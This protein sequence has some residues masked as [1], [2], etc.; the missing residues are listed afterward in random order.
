MTR[1]GGIGLV[2]A[3]ALGLLVLGGGEEDSPQ[4]KALDRL[5]GKLPRLP[6]WPVDPALVSRIGDALG[7]NRGHQGVDLFVPAKTDVVAPEA[8]RI[9]RSVNGSKGTTDSQKRAGQWVDAEG[10]E[11]GLLL[12]F[13]HLVEDPP[14]PVKAGQVLKRGDLIG[15][16]APTGSSGNFHSPPHLHLEARA[17]AERGEV[18]GPPLDPLAVL[19]EVHKPTLDGRLLAARKA[20]GA[21]EAA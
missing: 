9:I 19:P 5:R 14:L 7:A 17:P 15:R 12:R 11:S 3:L 10:L 2:L 21:T 4:N 13:L 16:V 8:L 18:Y 1:G 20:A 6:G